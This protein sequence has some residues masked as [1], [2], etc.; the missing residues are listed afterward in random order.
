MW[1]T[2]GI[3]V[4]AYPGEVLVQGCAVTSR[5]RVV[6]NRLW[7]VPPICSC[8]PALG[9]SIFNGRTRFTWR[10]SVEMASSLAA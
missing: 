1:Q 6:G 10:L 8:A 9:F 4:I 3:F 2:L 7:T 5:W